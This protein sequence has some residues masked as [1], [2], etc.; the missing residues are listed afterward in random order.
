MG[1]WR[2]DSFEWSD[3]GLAMLT[4]G[5]LTTMVGKAHIVGK[6]VKKLTPTQSFGRSGFLSAEGY[7]GLNALFGRPF[8]SKDFLIESGFGGATPSVATKL[9]ADI[10]GEAI[11]SAIGS[12]VESI[13]KDIAHGESIAWGKA[14]LQAPLGGASSLVGDCVGGWWNAKR[15]G[16]TNEFKEWFDPLWKKLLEKAN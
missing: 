8:D 9:N 14:F 2:T 5:A 11:I 10:G 7:L 4:T 15:W 3:L 16:E 13:A 6:N 1:A 12:S